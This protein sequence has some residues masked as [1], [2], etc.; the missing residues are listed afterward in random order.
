MS[1]DSFIFGGDEFALVCYSVHV[2][3]AVVVACCELES[4][5]LP[6]RCLTDKAQP[7]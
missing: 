4:F 7:T 5:A 3:H 1:I 6:S 2:Y